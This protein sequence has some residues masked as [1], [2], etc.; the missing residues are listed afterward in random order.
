MTDLHNL[1]N[2][3]FQNNHPD[4]VETGFDHPHDVLDDTRLTAD[5]KR[6]LL[7]FWA[8]DAN[9]V[10]HLPTLRQ[11]PNGSIVK[12]NDILNALK[13]LDGC[14]DVTLIQ[15]RCVPLWQRSLQRRRGVSSLKWFRY[16]RRSDDDDD[17]PPC[18]AFGTVRPRSGGG[19]AYAYP[20][21][22]SA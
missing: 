7:A 5:E 21:P 13:A 4:L 19:A 12:L 3:S 11:L 20:E 14:V 22:V 15:G 16:G 17:P 10:P 6:A 18:P 9:A 8:S 1:Q 2:T